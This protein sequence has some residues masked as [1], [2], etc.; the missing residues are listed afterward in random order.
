MDLI[1][2]FRASAPKALQRF[3]VEWLY[4]LM[5]HPRK[6]IKRMKKVILFLISCI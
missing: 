2:G 3:G 4:R 6:H 5:M 1:T